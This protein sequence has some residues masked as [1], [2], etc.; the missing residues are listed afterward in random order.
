MFNELKEEL[1]VDTYL[2]LKQ[3]SMMELFMKIVNH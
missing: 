1:K 3:V 2:E